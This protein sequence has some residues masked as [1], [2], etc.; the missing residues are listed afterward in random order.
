[1]L[2]PWP[3]APLA[4]RDRRTV[5]VRVTGADGETSAWSFPA[6]VEAA[7]LRP[8]DWT[9]RMIS[10]AADPAPLVRQP[11]R[12]DGS[13]VS[14]RLYI[15]AHGLYRAS[16]NG[17]PVSDDAFAPGW[18]TYHHR[19]RYQ[20]Y[21]VTGLLT[22]GDNVIGAQ[23]A[24]GWFRGRLSFVKGKRNVYG[25]ALGLL[26]QLEVTFG[27]RPDR[28]RRHRRLVEV[29]DRADTSAD[30]YEGETYDARKEEPGW[31]AAAI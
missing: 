5:R 24:D 3:A 22:D 18:T 30:L 14:A 17:R 7:L 12:L 11:F 29:L 16:I 1:M 6:I 26:A 28:R 25:D 23:L 8:A 10:P 15:T 20:T 4:S 13:V 2:V 19:L 21:D 31:S 27:R 9:A